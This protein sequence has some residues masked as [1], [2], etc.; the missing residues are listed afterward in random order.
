MEENNATKGVVVMSIQAITNATTSQAPTKVK[1]AKPDADK[2]NDRTAAAAAPKSQPK[3]AV[4]ISSAAKQALQEATETAAQ[5][6]KEAQSGDIQAKKL[7]AK[8][9]AVKAA[10]QQ[11]T[12]NP[13]NEGAEKLLK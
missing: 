6:A 11:P 2:D 1:E 7:L 12:A 4:Q 13:E 3:D 5:T 8:E 9:D 10:Q